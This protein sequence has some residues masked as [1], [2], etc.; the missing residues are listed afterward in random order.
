MNCALLFFYTAYLGVELWYF[1]TGNPNFVNLISVVF[2]FLLYAFGS[3][4]QLTVNEVSVHERKEIVGF[5]YKLCIQMCPEGRAQ[6]HPKT[7]RLMRICDKILSITLY[8]IGMNSVI[9]V[10]K[11]AYQL[12]H[13]GWIGEISPGSTVQHIMRMGFIALHIYMSAILWGLAT[14]LALVFFAV[15]YTVIAA[16]QELQM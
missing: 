2:L 7:W 10:C 16:I 15:A 14:M 13:S 4:L 1:A 9:I 3:V 12:D 5:I 6:S 11:A 8:G